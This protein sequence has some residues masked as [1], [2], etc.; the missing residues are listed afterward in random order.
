MLRTRAML[1]AAL[2]AV[3]VAA[4]PVS[5]APR[6][7][8]DSS[9]S[10][11]TVDKTVAL[12]QLKGEPLSTYSKTRPTKGKKIDFS[13]AAT[14]SYRA[15]LSARRNEFKQWLASNAPKVAIPKCCIST[16]KPSVRL[17]SAST[18]EVP[19]R[20]RACSPLVRWRFFIVTAL[21]V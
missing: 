21:L 2:V 11:P 15:L 10:R 7:Q 20:R 16:W 18:L 8:T 12:V 13:S 1:V 9:A 6:S 5:A 19:S 17:P 14:K 4:A 3:L